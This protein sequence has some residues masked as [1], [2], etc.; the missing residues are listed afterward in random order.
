M[1]MSKN[2]EPKPMKCDCTH[3]E[4]D[5][6]YGKGMRLHNPGGKASDYGKKWYCTVCSGGSGYRAKRNPDGQKATRKYKTS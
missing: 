4:Q 5:K 3:E 6:I 1:A 2:I